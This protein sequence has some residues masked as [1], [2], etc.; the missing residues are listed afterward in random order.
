MPRLAARLMKRNAVTE[1]GNDKWR[2]KRRRQR[3]RRKE[4]TATA[5]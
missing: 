5:I 3:G 1:N 4:Q 2:V